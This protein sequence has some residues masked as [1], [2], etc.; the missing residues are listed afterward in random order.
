MSSCI[1]ILILVTS[2]SNQNNIGFLIKILL[3]KEKWIEVDIKFIPINLHVFR[4]W[5]EF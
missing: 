5:S 1:Y 2:I 3:K 4:E